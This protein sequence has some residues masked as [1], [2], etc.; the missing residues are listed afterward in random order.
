MKTVHS[1]SSR[2]VLG[3]CADVY[4]FQLGASSLVCWIPRDKRKSCPLPSVAQLHHLGNSISDIVV[5][6]R[7]SQHVPPKYPF[8]LELSASIVASPV[9]KGF[10]GH[11]WSHVA[12]GAFLISAVAVSVS[13]ASGCH[14]SWQF[15]APEDAT[16][17]E[18][19]FDSCTFCWQ[20]DLSSLPLLLV[21]V[22]LDLP[23]AA[24]LPLCILLSNLPFC[25]QPPW[26]HVFLFRLCP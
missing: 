22:N 7:M 20:V 6:T 4:F 3:T 19:N 16:S 13:L 25:F 17:L 23:P 9:V 26:L 12:K 10:F 24:F 2:S 11:C 5:P 1:G 15:A 21:L 8:H 14:Y 18:H